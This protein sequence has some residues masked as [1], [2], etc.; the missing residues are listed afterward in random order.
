MLVYKHDINKY[1]PIINILPH[2]MISNDIIYNIFAVII[3]IYIM[4]VISYRTTEMKQMCGCWTADVTF[5]EQAGLDRMIMYIGPNNSIY[6]LAINTAGILVVNSNG[7]ME[8]NGGFCGRPW[9][10]SKRIFQCVFKF[11]DGQEYDS[12]PS[13]QQLEYDPR[14]MKIVMYDKD[15]VIRAILYKDNSLSD[16][17]STI[18]QK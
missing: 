3:I 17:R 13:V 7:T 5:C 10:T 1:C 18:Q 14:K 16:I 4:L 2:N 8:L 6:V 12:F 9:M 11:S 15:R